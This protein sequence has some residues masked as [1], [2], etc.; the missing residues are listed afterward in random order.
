MDETPSK[1]KAASNIGDAGRLYCRTSAIPKPNFK[2]LRANSSISVNTSK[3]YLEEFHE[4]R[5]HNTKS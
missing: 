5:V 1:Q 4:V 2:W 3:K